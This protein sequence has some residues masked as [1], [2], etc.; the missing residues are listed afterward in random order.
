MFNFYNISTE[1]LIGLSVAFGIGLL[2]GTERERH[3]QKSSDNALGVRTF[4][5]SA[6]IGAIS[7]Y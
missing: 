4:T 1:T 7:I 2:I 6:L 5:I 3:Q